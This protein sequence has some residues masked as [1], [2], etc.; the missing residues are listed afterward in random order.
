[1]TIRKRGSRYDV[2]ISIDAD[3]FVCSCGWSRWSEGRPVDGCP[4]CGGEVSRKTA[5][6]QISGGTFP[7]KKS[8]M[9]RETEL[10]YEHGQGTAV[11]KNDIRIGQLIDESLAVAAAD[12]KHGTVRTYR[13]VL[14]AY[15]SDLF[16]RRVQDLS[17]ADYTRHQMRLLEEHAPAT[18][19]LAR[20]AI[21]RCFKDAVRWGYVARNVIGDVPVPKVDRKPKEHLT[22]D[23]VKVLLDYH[24]SDELYAALV[25]LATT[26]MRRGEL[27]ALRR[28]DVELDTGTISIEQAVNEFGV[29]GPPKSEAGRRKIRIDDVTVAVLRRHLVNQGAE[30]L[31]LGTVYDDHGLVFARADGTAIPPTWFSSRFRSMCAQ[32]GVR[33]FGP[34]SMRHAFATAAITSNLPG[35]IISARLGHASEATTSAM[36]GRVTTE[37]DREVAETMGKRILG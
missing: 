16:N 4:E 14:D 5:R 23:E 32:A 22:A 6:R 10:R 28:S 26:G 33:K 7:D 25:T 2:L 13:K 15:A 20:A 27:L 18:V 3:Q 36:Y 21:F 9:R 19:K 34:H 11:V 8:A 30:R 29:V 37:M 1:M 12:R 24:R 35:R 17:A 31:R